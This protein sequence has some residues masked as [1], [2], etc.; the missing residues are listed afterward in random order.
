MVAV[1]PQILALYAFY[2]SDKLYKTKLA[3][4]VKTHPVG[5]GLVPPQ[6]L[7]LDTESTSI[8]FCNKTLAVNDGEVTN[9]MACHKQQVLAQAAGWAGYIHKGKVVGVNNNGKEVPLSC[10]HFAIMEA[11]S[12][13]PCVEGVQGIV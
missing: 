10:S 6:R 5:K 7:L 8:A 3:L 2:F 4:T 9:F 13:E 11:D 12:D 1:V